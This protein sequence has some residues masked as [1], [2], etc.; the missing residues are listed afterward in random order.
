M[1]R[2]P[3][4]GLYW[5][6]RGAVAC[7][8]HCPGEGTDTWEW[9]RWERIRAEDDPGNDSKCETCGRDRFEVMA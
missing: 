1:R 2:H 5:S 8:E 4:P 6:E 9:E 7:H 3:G